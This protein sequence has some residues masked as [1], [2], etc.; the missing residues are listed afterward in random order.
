VVNIANTYFSNKY[1]VVLFGKM[2]M[3]KQYREYPEETRL[4]PVV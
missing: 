2:E 3:K 1:S 4:P